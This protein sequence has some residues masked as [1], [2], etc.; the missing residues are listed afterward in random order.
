[1]STTVIRM[2]DLI[3]LRNEWK[4]LCGHYDTSEEVSNNLFS[5]IERRYSEP[6]RAYHNLNHIKEMLELAYLF[7]GNIQDYNSVCFA[8]WFHDVVY[9]TKAKD[10]EEQ[11]AALAMNL[12]Q[13]LKVPKET[14]LKIQHMIMATKEHK[15]EDLDHDTKIL[16]DA[17]LSILG[18]PE[19]R[20]KEY[21]KAIRQEYSWVPSFIYKRKRRGVLVSFLKR[22]KLYLTDQLYEMFE[23]QAR[24]N[25]LEEIK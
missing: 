1:M 17:D 10:N 19:E 20:Y 9:D 6:H 13:Q 21:S 24:R 15:A 4:V 16:L 8:I 25:I 22:D 23:K 2:E 3:F 12:L 5:I 7:K 14:L 18:A 11:S